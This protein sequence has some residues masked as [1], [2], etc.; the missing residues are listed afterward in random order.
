MYKTIQEEIQKVRASKLPHVGTTI[1]TTMSALANEHGALNLG[2]GFP[3]FEVDRAWGDLVKKHID[4]GR[5][6]YAPMPGIPELRNALAK[7]IEKSY[8]QE[9]DDASE[10][11]I[12]AGATQAIFTAIQTF[13]HASDEVI[14]FAPAYDCYAPAIELIGAKPIWIE[15]RYPDYQ[16]PW[17]EVAE[18]MNDRTSMIILNHPHN[19]SG[20]ALDASDIQQLISIT[21]DTDCMVLSDEVYEHILFDQRQHQSVLRYPELRNR[22]LA[23]FSFGKTFH[24]T[25]WKMGY[26]IGAAELM[27]E[28]KKVHQ[29]NVFCCNTPV[30]YALTEYLEDEE[31]Y[32]SIPSFYQEK[33]DKFYSQLQ[34]SNFEI[35]PSAGT[36]FQLLNYKNITDKSDIEVA[37]EWTTKYKI[38]TIPCSVFYPNQLDEKVLRVCFAKD[39]ATL[40]RAAEV[41]STIGS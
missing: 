11:T 10:I 6:Q 15:L 17:Q 12:T 24:L 8:H 34:S 35:L 29:Y 23:V 3:S 5:N 7:K 25:G 39:D 26:I 1:F 40:A 9:F 16:I 14:L 21:K 31:K 38:T 32:L 4:A 2:Q 27:Q 13:V 18:K 37:I 19:P 30:Q 20:A 22:S 41:L 33:R 28:F 36:Y